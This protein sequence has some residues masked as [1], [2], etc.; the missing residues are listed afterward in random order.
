MGSMEAPLDIHF[1]ISKCF[2]L[3]EIDTAFVD[4]D[5]R[6]QW[7]KISKVLE[8]SAIIVIANY[9]NGSWRRVAT[10]KIL[11]FI[12]LTFNVNNFDTNITIQYA[13]EY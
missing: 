7:L 13:K 3:D 10:S 6:S 8:A 2:H 9:P 5:K 4:Q 11:L 12:I 1:I